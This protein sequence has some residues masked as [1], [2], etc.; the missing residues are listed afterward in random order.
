MSKGRVNQRRY[1]YPLPIHPIDDL[2]DLILHNPISWVY[3]AYR[4]Y[5]STNALNEKVHVDFIGDNTIHIIVQDDKQMLY[6]WDNGFFGTGQFSRS[7]PTWRDRTEVRLGL[8][9]SPQ[10]VGRG[11]KINT[12]TQL[13]LERVTQQRRAQRLEFKKERARLERD[14]LELRKKGAHISEENI[15]LEKQRESLR[16]FKLKQ[17]EDISVVGQ[18]QNAPEIDLR[19]EDNDLLNENGDL[20][21]L[22]SLEL[23]PVEAMFLTFAL[24]VLEISSASLTRKLFPSDAKYKDIHSFVRSYVIYHHYRSHG[25]CVRS[26]IK[27]GCDYLLYKRGPPFQHAE[28]CIMGLD[29]DICKDYTWYSSI[30]RV[31]GAAKKTFVLCYVE[32]LISEEEAISLWKSNNF[33][34][35]FNGYQIGEVLYRRW[36]PGRNRD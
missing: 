25:W 17:M 29:Y 21:Q 33:T 12:E 30:A 8:N 32:R 11:G 2:P 22:E 27:F 7:E 23:M 19:N 1:K 5:K 4:Y 35:L 15:L 28:F 6:L 36:V 31:A 26:G 3:W 20:L 24:S 16:E 18:Q 34:K 13:T 9:D 10:Q 14:L